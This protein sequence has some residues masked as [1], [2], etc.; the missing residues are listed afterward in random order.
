MGRW[1]VFGAALPP[2]GFALNVSNGGSDACRHASTCDPGQL[3]PPKERN[4]VGTPLGT[5]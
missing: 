2:R 3:H 1:T 5:V 4:R